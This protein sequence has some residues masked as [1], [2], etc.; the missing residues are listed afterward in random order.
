MAAHQFEHLPSLYILNRMTSASVTNGTTNV[1]LG[2]MTYD[3]Y[4]Y[5]LIDLLQYSSSTRFRKPVL[6]LGH[7]RFRASITARGKPS[8][9]DDSIRH[10]LYGL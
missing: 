3:E 5:G 8:C 4:N 10:E 6:G 2:T 9:D 1:G 7:L